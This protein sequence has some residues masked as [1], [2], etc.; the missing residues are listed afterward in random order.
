MRRRTLSDGPTVRS[1]AKSMGLAITVFRAPARKASWPGDGRVQYEVPPR[2]T[3]VLPCCPRRSQV[4]GGH[5]K[6]DDSDASSGNDR[7]YLHYR[8][9]LVA[10]RSDDGDKGEEQTSEVDP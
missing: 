7:E 1:A 2:T 4:S 6:N 9:V 5:P 10:A 8:H 3:D